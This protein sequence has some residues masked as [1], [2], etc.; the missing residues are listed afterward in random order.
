[1]AKKTKPTSARALAKEVSDLK[2][3]V[4]RLSASLED[5]ANENQRN[6]HALQQA[7]DIAHDST[8]K[9]SGL[10]G[11]LAVTQSKLTDIERRLLAF[12]DDEQKEL[13]R[14]MGISGIDYAINHM[15]DLHNHRYLIELTNN[16]RN[17]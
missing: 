1:M 9:L 2:T 10:R 11:E 14:I 5:S 13:V 17:H 4:G 6:K 7:I 3:T 15:K 16:Y 12:L 8:N